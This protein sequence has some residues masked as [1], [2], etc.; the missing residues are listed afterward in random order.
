MEDIGKFME[1]EATIK[2]QYEDTV[3]YRTSNI[4]MKVMKKSGEK[5]YEIENIEVKSI[6]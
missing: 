6:E 1:G 2:S 3:K 4:K 5:N